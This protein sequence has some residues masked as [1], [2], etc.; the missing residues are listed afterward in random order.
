MSTLFGSLLIAH[1]FFGFVGVAASFT[2]TMLLI[3]N[4]FPLPKVKKMTL[5]AF[6]SYT[7]SWI[8][9]GWYYW[10]YYGA[11]VKPVIMN[12]DYTWAHAV[13]MEA[14]EHIFLFLPFATLVLALILHFVP[15]KVSSDSAFKSRVLF[16][17][18]VITTLAVIITLSGI[19]IT[20]GAR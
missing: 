3:K 1:V 17:S 19:L 4:E 8:V 10:K 18:L 2:V 12:G 7:I 11:N 5:W 13:F 16:L 15:E 6:L 9:G 20:G 14:K